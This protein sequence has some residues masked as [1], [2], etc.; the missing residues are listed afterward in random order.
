VWALSW[1]SAA[2]DPPMH[3]ALEGLKVWAMS[4]VNKCSSSVFIV[5]LTSMV[6]CQRTCHYEEHFSICFVIY[7]EH[8]RTNNEY[9]ALG[10]ER[11]MSA[12]T[13]VNYS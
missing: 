2:L 10:Y 11:C 5:L 3:P 7:M 8:M 9:I 1:P 13:A 12:L 6:S 4:S